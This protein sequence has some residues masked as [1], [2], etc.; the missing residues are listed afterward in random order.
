MSINRRSLI[1]GLSVFFATL[2]TK[3]TSVLAKPIEDYRI[4]LQFK[5]I[6]VDDRPL[7]RRLNEAAF[8]D[9]GYSSILG[10]GEMR[11]LAAALLMAAD[12]RDEHRTFLVQLPLDGCYEGRKVIFSVSELDPKEMEYGAEN[13]EWEDIGDYFKR[14]SCE[15]QGYDRPSLNKHTFDKQRRLYCLVQRTEEEKLSFI[16]ANELLS[17]M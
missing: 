2:G 4:Y 17:G 16:K 12:E 11:N 13:A 3:I 14:N 9:N 5:N 1:A 10:A 6:A 7:E 15:W 8:V